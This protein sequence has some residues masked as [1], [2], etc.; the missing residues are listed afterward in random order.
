MKH[1]CSVLIIDD[2]PDDILLAKRAIIKCRTD[3]TIEEVSSGAMARE[4]LRNAPLPS[5]VLLDLK[6][7]GIDGIDVL[8]DIRAHERTQY[9]PVVMFSSS[10][11]EED[12]KACYDAGANS[13]LYKSDDLLEFMHILNKTL[14]YWID[15]NLSPV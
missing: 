8:K 3:C 5:L 15:I 11:L 9:I 6:M 1:P 4:H 14:Q 7:P 10:T 12:I 2:N 13:F